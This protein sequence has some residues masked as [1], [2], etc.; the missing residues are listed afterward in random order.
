LGKQ[1]K[2]VYT[3]ELAKVMVRSLEQDYDKANGRRGRRR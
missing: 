3:L 1:E 2:T